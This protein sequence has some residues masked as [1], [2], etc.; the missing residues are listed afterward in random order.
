MGEREDVM[1][2]VIALAL[3]VVACNRPPSLD[4][5]SAILAFSELP[6][7]LAS[8]TTPYAP[9]VR[10]M[11]RFRGALPSVV[12]SAIAGAAPSYYG[13]FIGYVDTSG[14]RWIHGNFMCRVDHLEKS[15]GGES[16]KRG[17]ISV[18]DGGP[19][20]FRVDWSPDT[21]ATRNLS[22]NGDA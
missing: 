19:C 5:R 10:D 21:N 8:G 2:S 9:S 20:Y 7:Y 18:S 4:D 22:V 12:P 11:Q 13:Q 1:R 6:H 17:Y 15:F 3:L 14:Q 16:W